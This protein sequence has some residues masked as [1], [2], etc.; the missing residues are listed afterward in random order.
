MLPTKFLSFFLNQVL[1]RGMK[2][3]PTG[4]YQ[5]AIAYMVYVST[6]LCGNEVNRYPMKEVDI[7]LTHGSHAAPFISHRFTLFLR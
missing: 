5:K 7:Q 2:K 3:Q 4:M 1:L 6:H